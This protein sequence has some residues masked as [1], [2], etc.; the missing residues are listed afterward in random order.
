MKKIHEGKSFWLNTVSVSVRDI[1]NY[2]ISNDDA[3]NRLIPFFYLGLSMAS[4][5]Q[6][7][8]GIDAVQDSLQLF[9]EWEYHLSSFSVQSV[10]YVM[11][12]SL[13]TAYPG[14]VDS[15]EAATASS[16]HTINKFSNEVVY[17]KLQCPHVSFEL[18]YTAVVH[19]LCDVLAKLYE[20]MLSTYIYT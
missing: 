2:I 6:T 10:K 14:P 18:N 13:S 11:A 5:L 12:R 8:A 1:N 20:K 4:L 19:A 15:S 7:A 17:T 16:H 3:W 9:E